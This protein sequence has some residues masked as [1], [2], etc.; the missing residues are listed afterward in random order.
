MSLQYPINFIIFI[1]FSFKSLFTSMLEIRQQVFKIYDLLRNCFI[2]CIMYFP[3]IFVFWF[4][5]MLHNFK[6]LFKLY[7]HLCKCSFS[8]NNNTW[9]SAYTIVIYIHDKMSKYICM[10]RTKF[11]WKCL[12]VHMDYNINVIWYL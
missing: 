10:S 7:T 11:K 6:I 12:L 3:L 2:Y 4:I 1:T 5:F 8:A 9:S